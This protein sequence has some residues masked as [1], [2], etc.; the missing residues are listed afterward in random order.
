MKEK[1][2]LKLLGRG[3]EY[4]NETG[5]QKSNKENETKTSKTL[6]LKQKRAN[7]R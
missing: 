2:K 1:T 6:P 7:S 5:R 3:G 4:Y